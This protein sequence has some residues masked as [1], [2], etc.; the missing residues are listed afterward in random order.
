VYDNIQTG[1][2]VLHTVYAA[3]ENEAAVKEKLIKEREKT[4]LTGEKS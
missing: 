2:C 1:M 3:A 4:F